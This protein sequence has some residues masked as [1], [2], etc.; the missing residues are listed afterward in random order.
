MAGEAC[1]RLPESGEES[2]AAMIPLLIFVG[3]SI[4]LWGLEA[5]D[6]RHRTK[7]KR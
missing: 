7:K 5:L 1:R 3:L 6:T 2:E 4:L